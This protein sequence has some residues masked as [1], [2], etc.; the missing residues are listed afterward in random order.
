LYTGGK[1]FDEYMRGFF[2]GMIGDVVNALANDYDA[3]GNGFS[4]SIS[5][6]KA[7]ESLSDFKAARQI[8]K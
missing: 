6:E 4:F 2:F 3:L 5:P 8:L 1:P 7:K